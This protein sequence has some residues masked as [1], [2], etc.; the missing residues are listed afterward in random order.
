MLIKDLT[1][2]YWYATCSVIDAYRYV[3]YTVIIFFQGLDV[4]SAPVFKD[5]RLQR[6]W[7]GPV[8][9]W[10]LSPVELL[11]RRFR[12]SLIREP[13]CTGTWMILGSPSS[14]L[15]FVAVGVGEL[16]LLSLQPGSLVLQVADS[17]SPVFPLYCLLHIR[18]FVRLRYSPP[19]V[20]RQYL[21]LLLVFCLYFLSLN[22][23]LLI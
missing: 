10:N 13:S 21:L 11:Q 16:F 14:G 2:S 1:Y 12:C 8:N 6:S 22:L 4:V 7:S 17:A 15:S 5:D 20:I 9:C 23:K 3:R 19:P 18:L